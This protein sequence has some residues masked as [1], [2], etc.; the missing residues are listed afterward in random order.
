[1]TKPDGKPVNE[2]EAK[3][4]SGQYQQLEETIQHCQSRLMKLNDQILELRLALEGVKGHPHDAPICLR[5]Y[6]GVLIQR[7]CAEVLVEVSKELEEAKEEQRAL[8]EEKKHA[9][10]ERNTLTSRYN[11]RGLSMD[12]VINAKASQQANMYA[13]QLQK[14]YQQQMSQGHHSATSSPLSGGRRS[15][16]HR[17]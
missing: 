13:M 6:S 1:M 11:I 16:G 4:I 7:T 2:E 12:E 14:Q 8:K 5:E 3:T 15:T 9:Q 17:Y 10:E